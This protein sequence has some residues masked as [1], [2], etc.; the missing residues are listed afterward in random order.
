MNLSTNIQNVSRVQ[1]LGDGVTDDIYIMSPGQE[2]ATSDL[3]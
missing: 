2:I 3:N 1:M